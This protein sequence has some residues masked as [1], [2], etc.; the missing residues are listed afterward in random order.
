MQSKPK[1]MSD[2]SDRLKEGMQHVRGTC[3]T[4]LTVLTESSRPEHGC[5]TH[6]NVPSRSPRPANIVLAQL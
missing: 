2:G 1:D 4:N 3:C 6:N 5:L